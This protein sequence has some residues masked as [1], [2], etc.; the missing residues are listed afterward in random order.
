MDALPVQDEGSALNHTLFGKLT[1]LS[2]SFFF[3]F[4][5]LFTSICDKPKEHC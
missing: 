3:G 5:C 2:H 4:F 1:L